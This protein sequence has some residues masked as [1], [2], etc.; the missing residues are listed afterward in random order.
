MQEKKTR[1]WIFFIKKKS[2]L[3]LSLSRL[4]L[5]SRVGYSPS[6]PRRGVGGEVNRTGRRRNR[7]LPIREECPAPCR[8]WSRNC[9]GQCRHFQPFRCWSRSCFAPC[10]RCRVSRYWSLS[11]FGWCHRCLSFRCWS[12]N[13]FGW[14]RRYRTFRHWRRSYC[15]LCRYS[16]SFHTSNRCCCKR[17][18]QKWQKLSWWPRPRS[19][20]VKLSFF[21]LFNG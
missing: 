15:A 10:R 20:Y 3:L 16:Q 13:C 1:Y 5:I 4:F 7:P 2:R 12:R 21:F 17:P 6:P 18:G 9:F 11:C 19:K 8:C 14:C